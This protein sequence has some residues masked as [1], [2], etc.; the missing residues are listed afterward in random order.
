MNKKNLFYILISMIFCLLVIR[1]INIRV[2]NHDY[3]L[4][5]Y[6]RSTQKVISNFTA[7]RGRILDTNGNVIVD[8]KK[9]PI[10][11]YRKIDNISKEEEIDLAYKLT[12][13]LN[14]TKEAEEDLLKEFYLLTNDTNYLLTEQEIKD[15]EYRKI[16]NEEIKKI[17]LERIKDE[18]NN[19]SL[20]DRIAI[21]TYYLLNK[22]YYYDT[23]I[24]LDNAS[25]D[26]C[27]LIMEEDIKGVSCSYKYERVNNYNTLNQIIGQ[28]AMIQYE[29]KDYYLSRGY[30]ID[31]IVGI[32]GL[33]LY[34][35]ELLHG[36]PA[37]YIVKEDN[38][39][40]LLEEEKQGQDLILN[41]DINIQLRLDEILKENIE[42]T[43]NYKYTNYYKGSY[44]IISNP[45]TGGILAISGFQRLK[46]NNNIIY[47]DVTR[48]II[49]SSF[50]VGSVIK[51]ASHTVGYLNNAIEIGKKINDSCVKLYN[52]PEK[53]SYKKLG[54]IDDITALK[55]S[56][57]YYQFITAIKTTGNT[58][59]RNMQLE[60]SIDDFNR[61]RDVFKH[62]GLGSS[63]YIDY[64][65]E[66]T[67]ITGDKISPDLLLNFAIGQYDTYTPIQLLSYINT[68][69]N[70]GIRY[71]LSFKKDNTKEV[72]N[73]N[74]DQ[75][76]LER[77]QEGFYQV[78]NYGTARGY[79]SY[80]NNGVGKTGTA[81]NYY[82]GK[83]TTINQTFAGY[84]P[85]ENPQYSLVVV[86]PNISYETDNNSDYYNPT[87]R[88]ISRAITN[89]LATLSQHQLAD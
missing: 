15:L 17:K 11:I 70:N 20:E 13:V 46:D 34:Y 76:Y 54:Y 28:T 51:G 84:F 66:V 89:Y 87:T 43:K 32:S 81:Q 7:P 27:A 22:G 56:S 78:V 52:V 39:I 85:R 73:I 53:C 67:G 55:T 71:N 60:V 65:G 42:K 8:N 86:S 58:Y 12:R 62:F 77:I 9:V 82:D 3:Y 14:L 38:S 36:T 30:N 57:N 18:I 10:I 19:Y 5:L 63:T 48:D 69:S 25:N 31:E 88:N 80:D 26:L 45:N 47:K 72:D 6:S 64:P 4:T 21:N 37:K 2:V 1:F 75:T 16:S 41:I 49:T 44:A 68:I 74:L 33:E 61:Y 35:E 79:I 24:L 40:K 23:K 59:K 83:T 29:D 50:T